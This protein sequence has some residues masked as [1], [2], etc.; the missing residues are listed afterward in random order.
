[1]KS[2]IVYYSYNGNTKKVVGV[3]A[4]VLSQ[5]GE[6]S[7]IELMPLDETKNFFRQCRR[8]IFRKKALLSAVNFDLSA[9]DL[10]C[11]A[12]PVWAFG[13]APAMNTYLKNCFGVKGKE[14]ILCVTFGSGSGVRRCVHYMQ[15]I[16]EAAG[17]T[18]FSRLSIQQ[19]R[20]NDKE[21]IGSEIKK[22]WQEG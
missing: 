2:A 7:Q 19:F 22:I 14:I 16:L 13:P 4:Q 6:V 1:M 3:L 20:V 5:K 17:A 12:T 21:F 11:F 10:V 9:Y 15:D 8:A 18:S